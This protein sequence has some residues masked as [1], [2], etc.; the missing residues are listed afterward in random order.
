M[1]AVDIAILVIAGTLLA[2]LAM[3]VLTRRRRRRELLSLLYHETFG[4]CRE[5]AELAEEICTRHADGR[6]VDQAVLVRH[7]LT[8]P[9]TYPGLVPSL[10]RLPRGLG[11]RAVEFHGHL[12]LARTRL[13]T[14]RS[15]ER[16]AISTY[17]LVSALL[18]SANAG[19]GILLDCARGLGWRKKW[20]KPEMPLA[21]AYIGR[22]ERA[23]PDLMDWGYWSLPS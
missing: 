4:L 14:W 10:W 1:T 18:R 22:T 2:A 7:A 17:L 12:C 23:E 15:G 6:S 20:W 3:A 21:N 5:A 19:D 16:D 11:W 8:E 9:R 13:A